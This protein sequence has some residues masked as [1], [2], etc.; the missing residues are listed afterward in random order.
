M[1]NVAIIPARGGSKRILRKNIRQFAGKPIISWS[2]NAAQLSDCFDRILVSTDDDEIA[3]VA[4]SAGAEVP[5]RRPNELSDD[6]A[7]TLPVVAHAINWLHENN[8]HPSNVCCIYATAPF[9]L[10]K[11][12][13]IGLDVLRETCRDFSVS[14]TPF[15]YP[16][17][18][19][20][21]ITKEFKIVMN[22]QNYINSR[23]QDLEPMYHDAGQFYWGKA[24]A[25]LNTRSILSENAAP[26]ILPRTRVQDIDSLD[27]WHQAE[28]MFHAM[29]SL[30]KSSEV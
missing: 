16:V 7:G 19:S 11:D 24:E 12:L 1:L 30:I 2:I 4:L 8:Y 17:Q 20:L 10:P 25:W 14:V 13:A 26:V 21:R 28:L 3:S 27:D 22:D 9:L 23:S 29:G 6:Y 5:F 15:D 18:R